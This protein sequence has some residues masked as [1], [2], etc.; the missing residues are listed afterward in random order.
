MGS[1]LSVGGHFIVDNETTGAFTVT[2]L[3]AATGSTGVVVPQGGRT[4]LYSD[5]VNV[6]YADDAFPKTSAF[7]TSLAQTVAFE[8]FFDGQGSV[9][10]TGIHAYA[11]VPFNCNI[12]EWIMASDQN[13]LSCDI[14]R[15]NAA[16]PTSSAQ[17][18]VGGGTQPQSSGTTYAAA[19]PAG[20][21]STAL[22]KNDCL[23][24]NVT[25][26]ANITKCLLSLRATRTGP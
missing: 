10:T 7:W 18:I 14:W 17:S 16:L 12:T 2:V 15:A 24:F 4:E 22:L 26:A 25:S 9:I 3:T 19:A 6:W 5:T 13:G 1:A 8:P 21:T 23:V 20:W 11:D